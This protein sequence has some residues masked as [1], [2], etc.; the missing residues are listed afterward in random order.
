MSVKLLYEFSW[1]CGRSGSIDG[2]FVSTNE[3]VSGLIGKEVYFG[4][5]LGKHSEVYGVIEEGDITEVDIDADAVAKVSEKLGD[6]WS[7]FNPLHY[8][9]EEECE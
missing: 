4:E 9:E 8:I 7:G 2:L 1:D 5:V 3:E 6:T